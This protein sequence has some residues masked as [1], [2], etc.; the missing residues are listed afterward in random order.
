MKI[1]KKTVFK[2]LKKL[3]KAEVLEYLKYA[4]EEMDKQ[5]RSSVFFELYTETAHG[6]MKPKQL[7]KKVAA[8]YESSAN[9]DYY[10]PFDI[11]S[12]NFM[13]VPAE[14]DEWFSELSYYLDQTSALVKQQHYEIA[15]RCFEKLFDTIDLLGT[16][17]VVFADEAGDWM[18][19]AK[20]D[21]RYAYI[22]ALAQSIG[23][24]EF[25]EQALPVLEYNYNRTYPLETL[26]KIK[27]VI[28]PEQFNEL[29]RAIEAKGLKG[30]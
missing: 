10:A 7:Y 2:A 12:K 20:S 13:E 28:T 9:G 24:E 25:A 23:V 14:T 1:K 18:I 30:R 27:D 26:A 6:N 22:V 8:F 3:K 29:Q 15:V 5:Q 21:Y 11:N 17:E 4:F 16:G 19:H